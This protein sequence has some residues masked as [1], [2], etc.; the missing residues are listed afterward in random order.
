M[1]SN[2]ASLGEA[3]LAFEDVRGQLQASVVIAAAALVAVGGDP[4]AYDPVVQ[5][6]RPHGGQQLVAARLR[7][8]LAGQAG[9]SSRPPDPYGHPAPP[10]APRP[11]PDA[12]APPAPGPAGRPH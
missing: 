11:G 7:E 6:A 8:L 9:K 12:P 4:D 3:A 2:A 1:S 10:P 5:Q